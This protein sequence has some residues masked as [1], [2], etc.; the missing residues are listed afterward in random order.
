MTVL[1]G[2][3]YCA[4]ASWH[5][6]HASFLNMDFS[7][8]TGPHDPLLSHDVSLDVNVYTWNSLITDRSLGHGMFGNSPSWHTHTQLGLFPFRVW[9]QKPPITHRMGLGNW[10]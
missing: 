1:N 7:W 9:A 4:D 2:E 8:E 6:N 10:S 5:Y 3:K